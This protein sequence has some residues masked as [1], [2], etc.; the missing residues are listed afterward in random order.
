M[1]F[2]DNARINPDKVSRRGRNTGIAVGGGSTLLVIGLFIASQVLG[3]DLTG[4]VGGGAPSGEQEQGQ[5]L[6]EC[7]TAEKANSGIDCRIAGAADSLDTYWEGQVD[8]YR[9]TNVVL[10]TDQVNTGCGGATSATGPFYCPP[11]EKIYVDTAFYDDLRSRFGSSG[12]PLAE[13]YVIAHEWGHHI[14]NSTGVM[15]GLDRQTTGPS[16]DSVRL[17]LQADC[18]AGAWVGAASTITND[19][20]VVFLDPVTDAQIADALSAA[21]AVGDDRIQESTQGQVTPESWTHGSSDKRQQWFTTGLNGGPDACN[22]FE[23]ATP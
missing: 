8:G 10:F 16:S 7:T 18:F 13:M 5:A 20:G 11:D 14:Q 22:T 4:L 12:G 2:N 6:T 21:S 17:E 3:V 15:E 23:V 9:T 19:D 1:T